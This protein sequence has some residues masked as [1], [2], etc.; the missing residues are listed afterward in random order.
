[1]SLGTGPVGTCPQK[2]RCTKRGQVHLNNMDLTPFLKCGPQISLDLGG[3][4]CVAADATAATF[5]N[6]RT[7]RLLTQNILRHN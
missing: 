2:A 7:L 5:K 4:Y 3:F 1:M 6:V